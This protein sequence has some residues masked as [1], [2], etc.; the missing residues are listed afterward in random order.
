M[1][2][3]MSGM[4]AN[5][6]RPRC[7]DLEGRP[8]DT[9]VLLHRDYVKSV[10]PHLQRVS[11]KALEEDPTAAIPL[12]VLKS[13]VSI[14]IKLCDKA[15][16]GS[17][18][19]A[20]PLRSTLQ[21]LQT[22]FNTQEHN[23]M[24]VPSTEVLDAESLRESIE[25]RKDDAATIVASSASDIS[26]ST[27]QNSSSDS[28]GTSIPPSSTQVAQHPPKPPPICPDISEHPFDT[29]LLLSRDYINELRPLIRDT[30]NTVSNRTL[31]S[32]VKNSAFLCDGL[33]D[34]DTLHVLDRMAGIR[35]SLSIVRE[36]VEQNER[37]RR[38]KETEARQAE[39]L[40]LGPASQ[41]N[42]D[43]RRGARLASREPRTCREVIIKIPSH[44][45]RSSLRLKSGLEIQRQLQASKRMSGLNRSLRCSG[46]VH[47][48]DR[49][50][51]GKKQLG[52]LGDG[53][54]EQLLIM[55]ASKVLV[56]LVTL[57]P[58]VRTLYQPNVFR[59]SQHLSS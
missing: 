45:I 48:S 3:G 8:F 31:L 42:S 16:A 11:P 36:S 38:E 49:P 35:S 54:R 33:T 17:I 56:D 29:G 43:E 40:A 12:A 50:V 20:R 26:E 39:N 27:E 10:G 22:F 25:P 32:L 18:D 24:D 14:C 57:H 46:R 23:R 2:Q 53:G 34:W 47:N 37:V 6:G 55:C 5:E 19:D 7:P 21:D 59:P 30:S 13:T 15:D 9:A 52:G 41:N 58:D 1:G 44:A 4:T 28:D 51:Q